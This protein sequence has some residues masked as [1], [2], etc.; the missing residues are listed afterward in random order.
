MILLGND[1]LL[2]KPFDSTCRYNSAYH[3]TTYCEQYGVK[4]APTSSHALEHADLWPHVI[5]PR[6]GRR[7]RRRMKKKQKTQPPQKNGSPPFAGPQKKT[8]M[9]TCSLCAKPGHYASTCEK[10]D[11][12]LIIQSTNCYIHYMETHR[13]GKFSSYYLGFFRYLSKYK[14]FHIF[15]YPLFLRF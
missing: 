3:I 4:M 2:V 10:P 11:S 9:R 8:I 7:K 5:K 6:G 12:R 13:T 15:I 14:V 1:L